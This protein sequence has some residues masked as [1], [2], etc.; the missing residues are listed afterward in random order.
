MHIYTHCANTLHTFVFSYDG[1][2][3]AR[4]SADTINT[5][6]VRCT[7]LRTVNLNDKCKGTA[8]FIFNQTAVCNLTTLAIGGDIVCDQNLAIIGTHAKHLQVLEIDSQ[9]VHHSLCDLVNKCPHLRK[10]HY[11][12]I[13]PYDAKNIPE[14]MTSMY[15]V[16]I[17]PGVL[18][19]LKNVWKGNWKP[20]KPEDFDF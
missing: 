18:I 2:N 15:W 7:Q 9:C 16:N 17:R 13:S 8:P 19:T 3:K 4:F 14:I 20:T 12:L 6:F 5:L 11:N 10:L 1:F